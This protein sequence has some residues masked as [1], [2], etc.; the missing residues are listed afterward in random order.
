[1]VCVISIPPFPLHIYT[2]IFFYLDN[3]LNR[4]ISKYY[5]FVKPQFRQPVLLNS[6]A[7]TRG[8]FGCKSGSIGQCAFSSA[9]IRVHPRPRGAWLTLWTQSIYF[10]LNFIEVDSTAT[11]W[12]PRK[13]LYA[14]LTR[15]RV[16]WR[17]ASSMAIQ[18]STVAIPSAS[19]QIG[20]MFSRML[21]TKFSI[22][23][24]HSGEPRPCSGVAAR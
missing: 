21:S 2:L 6:D 7:D 23:N 20:W 14:W 15:T 4:R 24:F 18:V 13:I 19:G 12:S 16:A 8:F 17:M 3:Y 1:M 5:R 9:L 11:H 22:S 10:S